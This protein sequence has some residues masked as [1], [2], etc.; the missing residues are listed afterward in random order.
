MRVILFDID[1]TLVLTGR[2][3]QFALSRVAE[4]GHE[5][6]GK[7]PERSFAGRT[8]RAII[9]DYLRLHGIEETEPNFTRFCTKFLDELP[10]QLQ[11]RKGSVLPG[12]R[13]TLDRLATR[14]DL[15]LGLLTGNLRQ[16]AWLKLRHYELHHYFYRNGQSVLGAFGDEHHDRDDVAQSALRHARESLQASIT[17]DDVWIVGDTPLDV[18]CA[19]AIGARIV[20]VATGG[21]T[22]QELSQAGADLVLSTLKDAQVW[23][24]LLDG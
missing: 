19:K 22:V 6:T 11:S 1:G 23:L 24:E 15:A 7:Q 2:A 9:S 5:S 12:V 4:N 21:F 10:R 13:E 14:S 18:R 17:G 8:D 16:A 3:G 20:G